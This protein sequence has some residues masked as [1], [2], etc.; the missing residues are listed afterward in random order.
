M[1]D[2]LL[3]CM[4]MKDSGLPMGGSCAGENLVGPLEVMVCAG[5]NLCWCTGGGGCPCENLVSIQNWIS[6]SKEVSIL[7]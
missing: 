3:V 4:A 1:F 6:S 2:T 7:I 5:E